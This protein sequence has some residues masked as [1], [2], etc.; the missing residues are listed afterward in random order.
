MSGPWSERLDRLRP[1]PVAGFAGIT[2]AI[3]GNRIWL[4]WTQADTT[5]PA[6]LAY[7]IPITAFVAASVVVIVLLWRGVDRSAAGLRNLVHAFAAGT[8]VFW[9]IRLPMILSHPHAV[10]FKVVH[11]ILAVVSVGAAVAA[12]RTLDAAPTSSGSDPL[13]RADALV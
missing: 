1:Y 10:P 5:L 12:W 2:L 9:A 8:G 4:A 6:K 7:S 3:W 11:A 13:A